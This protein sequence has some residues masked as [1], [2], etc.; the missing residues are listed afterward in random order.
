MGLVSSFI[1]YSCVTD[2]LLSAAAHKYQASKWS[3]TFALASVES[4]CGVSTTFYR[5]GALTSLSK[6]W[7][8][9]SKSGMT[10]KNCQSGEKKGDCTL[11]DAFLEREEWCLRRRQSTLCQL[12]LFFTGAGADLR[13]LTLIKVTLISAPQGDKHSQ[14]PRSS[15]APNQGGG[16]SILP[17]QPHNTRDARR[18][19]VKSLETVVSAVDNSWDAP[20]SKSPSKERRRPAIFGLVD[21][22]T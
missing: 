15:M 2:T 14:L 11:H 10:T 13:P 16:E 12:K 18:T 19:L 9:Q 5:C 17:Q 1:M 7:S 22:W 4:K 3:Y 6:T 8:P 20:R 21:T